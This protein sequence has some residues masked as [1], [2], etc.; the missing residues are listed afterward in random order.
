MNEPNADWW[1][2]EG[3]QEGCHLNVAEQQRLILAVARALR[4]KQLTGT[5]V[6][7]PDT[8]S[9]DAC[10][11]NLRAYDRETI[12]A[13]GQIN[14]HSYDGDQRAALRDFARGHGKR[15]WQSESGPLHVQGDDLHQQLVMADRIVRDIHDMQAEA[16]VDWQFMAGATWG[17]VE[18]D[19]TPHTF[20]IKKKFHVYAQFS[21]FIR[22]GDRILAVDA[23][24]VLAA[25]S[26][27]HQRLVVVLVN[28]EASA[29]TY[30]LDLRGL[31]THGREAK[32]W[33]TS[34]TEDFVR[35]PS[36]DLVKDA[37]RI[38][39]PPESVTTVSIAAQELK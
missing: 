11:S 37:V 21:R 32:G 13:I 25:A 23:P 22:P 7:A 9:I 31:A 5:V 20:K 14:V 1:K 12:A 3:R 24:H 19:A 15:L 10:V 27:R 18:W 35:L 26:P 8:N 17:C 2:A 28:A 6:S 29:R 16:W 39:A 36:M 30:Q 33:R 34:V 38:T 4:R